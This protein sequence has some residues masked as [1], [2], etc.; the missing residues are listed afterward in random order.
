MQKIKM[1]VI[2]QCKMVRTLLRN[3]YLTVGVLLTFAV[4]EQLVLTGRQNVLNKTSLPK[5]K[6]FL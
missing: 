3:M 2:L 4:G 1:M 5:K 6:R